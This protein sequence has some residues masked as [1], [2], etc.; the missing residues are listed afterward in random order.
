M[1]GIHRGR[2]NSPHKWPVTRK[3][4][5]FD[6][7]IM[8]WLNTDKSIVSFSP[9]QL[10]RY[11]SCIN[12]TTIWNL[13]KCFTGL[14]LTDFLWTLGKLDDIHHYQKLA[15]RPFL[16]EWWCIIRY[17]AHWVG[18]TFW[19]DTWPEK[20]RTHSNISFD[21]H[22]KFHLVGSTVEVWKGIINFIQQIIMDVI[23]YLCW[24]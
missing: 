3:M 1:W 15:K 22:V 14:L 8:R 13:R 9:L 16:D 2:V 11:E 5:P 20:A 19:N 10:Q 12:C 21:N 17:I 6:D 18:W 23:T 7:V 24:G 4:L